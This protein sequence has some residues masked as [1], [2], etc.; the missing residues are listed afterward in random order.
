M[1]ADDKPKQILD[2]DKLTPRDLRMAREALPGMN[3]SAMLNDNIDM[4]ALTIF[5]LRRRENPEFSWDE[6]LDTPM[7]EFSQ[8]AGPPDPPTPEPAGNG[9]SPK[10]RVS[11]S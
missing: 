7:S 2:P 10:R 1:P 8:S 5:C 9:S 6:A 3:V 11:V 4:I